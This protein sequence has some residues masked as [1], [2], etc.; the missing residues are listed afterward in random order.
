M[1]KEWNG[2]KH[3]KRTR[4]WAIDRL[5]KAGFM[6]ERD[7]KQLCP[8]DTGRLRASI[9]TSVDKD[10]LK[11]KI[12]AGG[13]VDESKVNTQRG[14]VLIGTPVKYAIFVEQGTHK[15]EAQPYMVPAL[16]KNRQA[17]RKLFGAK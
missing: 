1:I 8:V 9:M 11:A 2:E 17:I 10:G 7:A 14:Q 5:W 12:K 13:D 4:D 16:E 3:K 6:V 15:M